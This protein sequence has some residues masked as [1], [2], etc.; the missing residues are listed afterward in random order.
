MAV[1][2]FHL[3][4]GIAIPSHVLGRSFANAVDLG[5]LTFGTGCPRAIC[6]QGGPIG[7]PKISGAAFEDLELD[8]G[9][10]NFLRTANVVQN[11]AVAGFALARCVGAL[12]PFE[13][14]AKIVVGE[15][16]LRDDIAELFA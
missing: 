2:F 16:L 14:R 13:F 4:Y 6:R 15:F 11:S 9:R 8:G 1:R 7:Q 3:A 5:G 10:P 12:S